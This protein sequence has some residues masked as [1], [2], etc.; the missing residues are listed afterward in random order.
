MLDFY[1]KI[2]KS[3]VAIIRLYA[4]ISKKGFILKKI[5]WHQRQ[6]L[7]AKFV[8]FVIH[9]TTVIS[10]FFTTERAFVFCPTQWLI[11]AILQA[12]WGKKSEIWRVLGKS[13]VRAPKTY[14]VFVTVL[15]E[16]RHHQ[17]VHRIWYDW[18]IFY[19]YV[20]TDCGMR[21]N[22]SSLFE[23]KH[24]FRRRRNGQKHWLFG[25]GK[26]E[27]SKK[28][29]ITTMSQKWPFPHEPKKEEKK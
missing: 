1:N 7:F 15:Q 13:V 4:Q 11:N 25:L 20:D 8:R 26:T 22:E 29:C 23:W 10:P 16:K 24:V 21:S 3:I 2:I 14:S 27:F 19:M 18:L 17:S 12:V 5:H 28:K 6:V 9:S